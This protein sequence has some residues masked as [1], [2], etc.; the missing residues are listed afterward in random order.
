MTFVFKAGRNFLLLFI[1]MLT[2]GVL[3]YIGHHTTF[4]PLT[5]MIFLFPFIIAALVGISKTTTA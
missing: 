3:A 2:G 4:I 1:G 5:T